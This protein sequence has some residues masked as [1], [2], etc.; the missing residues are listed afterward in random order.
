MTSST[1]SYTYNTPVVDSTVIIQRCSVISNI[2]T[3]S[4]ELCSSIIFIANV[5]GTKVGKSILNS[6][7]LGDIHGCTSGILKSLTSNT[8]LNVF[9]INCEFGIFSTFIYDRSYI[10]INR[11]WISTIIIYTI[12]AAPSPV[13]ILREVYIC[14]SRK[15]VSKSRNLCFISEFTRLTILSNDNLYWIVVR[16]ASLNFHFVSRDRLEKGDRNLG[17]LKCLVCST[18]SIKIQNNILILT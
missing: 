15:Y 7:N 9:G 3:I 16:T 5:D 10:S 2:S 4:A 6:C 12:I 13:V 17:N 8:Q 1:G 18:G 11:E 14:S